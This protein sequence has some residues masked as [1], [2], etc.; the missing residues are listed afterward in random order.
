LA[1]LTAAQRAALPL[2]DFGVPSK[3]P[4]PGSFPMPD[5]SHAAN[6]KSRAAQTAAPSVEKKIDAKANAVMA[7]ASPAK[8]MAP[9]RQVGRPAT[10]TANKGKHHAAMSAAFEHHMR[11]H[12]PAKG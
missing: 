10:A 9:A 12:G 8:A 4:G 3:A 5:A 11:G 7:K 1:R 6:A 2:S